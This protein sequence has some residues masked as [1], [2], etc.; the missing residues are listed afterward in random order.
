MDFQFLKGTKILVTGGA[1]LLGTALV[2]RL[3]GLGAEVEASCFSRPPHPALAAHYRRY[4]FNNYQDCLDATAGKDIAIVC[5]V[6]ASGV[7]G[8][9]TSPAATLMPNLAIHAGLFEA[10]SAN[11]VKK[12]VWV[13]SSTVYQ[14]ANYP[15]REEELDLNLPV[16]ELYA[17]IGWVYR[18]LEKLA[19]FYHQKLGL[20]IGVIRTS[21]I[22]GPYDRFDA[23]KSHVIPALIRRALAGETPFT[24]WGGPETVRD[25]I[26]VDDLV[27]GVLRQLAVD[28]HADP[29]NVSNGTPVTIKELAEVVTDCCGHP[30]P[31][32]FDRSK[33]SAVPYRVLDNSKCHRLL[34]AF[35]RTSLREGIQRTIEWYRSPLAR[36]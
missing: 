36:D 11:Q 5:A 8:V 1:G 27:E 10:M 7:Q 2:R 17:G 26:Y 29:I 20:N 21:N 31:L 25:F 19:E 22:Y 6:Q 23:A 4:D 24:V 13:S 35:P 32:D 16:F 14:E 3:V 28:C 9:R 30:G 12:A 18:Y 15:I 34:G 33:P